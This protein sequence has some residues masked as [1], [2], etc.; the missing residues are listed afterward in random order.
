[1][2]MEWR[3]SIE[4]YEENENGQGRKVFVEVL[5]HC[6]DFLILR[7]VFSNLN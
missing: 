5:L 6:H 7:I 2:P 3:W 4:S 1:M